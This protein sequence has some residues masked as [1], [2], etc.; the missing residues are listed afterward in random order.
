ML[1]IGQDGF[2]SYPTWGITLQEDTPCLSVF[3]FARFLSLLASGVSLFCSLSSFSLL[4][5]QKSSLTLQQGRIFTTWASLCGFS[6]QLGSSRQAVLF[7]CSFLGWRSLAPS[8][9]SVRCLVPLALCFTVPSTGV[10]LS[11]PV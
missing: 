9:L 4:G 11:R 8:S 10:P 2:M 7:C 3:K 1:G 6:P 5:F